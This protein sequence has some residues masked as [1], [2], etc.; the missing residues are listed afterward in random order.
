MGYVP[1]VPAA[2]VPPRTP[3]EALKVTP[4]GSAP[5]SLSVGTGKPVAATVK[6]P[7]APTVNVTLFALV[8]AADWFTV[9]VKFCVASE[10]IPLWAVKVI[11][12]APPELAAGV[13]ERTP[14]AE[15]N[16]TPGGN[17]P[18]SLN[19]GAGV[20]VAVTVNVPVVPTVNVV[21]FALV[22]AAD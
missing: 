13:P 15:L 2:G 9:R 18:D 5:D 20:P 7:A 12:Y 1:A 3:I 19:I 21:L 10:P 16:V 6:V 11:E 17:A 22:I 4:V 14:V 8:I